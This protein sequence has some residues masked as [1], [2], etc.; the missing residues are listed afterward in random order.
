MP[1]P[2]PNYVHDATYVEPSARQ[3][4]DAD[5]YRLRL[6]LGTYSEVKIDPVVIIRLK[7]FDAVELTSPKGKEARDFAINLLRTRHVTVATDK[8]I[9]DTTF[10]RTV[11]DVWVGDDK[12]SDLLRAAGYEK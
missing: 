7:G 11:A 12:L 4:P 3:R 6:D 9:S 8:P 2:I 5:T 10:V 1:A